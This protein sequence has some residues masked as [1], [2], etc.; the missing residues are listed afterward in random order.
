MDELARKSHE[1][2]DMKVKMKLKAWLGHIGSSSIRGSL[3]SAIFFPFRIYSLN[4]RPP[5]LRLVTDISHLA[6]GFEKYIP[7]PAADRKLFR[8]SSCHRVDHQDPKGR[9]KQDADQEISKVT[10]VHVK[11]QR[12][13]VLKAKPYCRQ[14]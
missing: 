6:L 11:H 10:P 1:T 8:R 3:V 9:G 12:C 5:L 7:L 4:P 2:H 14:D 13:T